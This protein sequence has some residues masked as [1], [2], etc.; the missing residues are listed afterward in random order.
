MEGAREDDPARGASVSKARERWAQG[1]RALG[2]EE[3]GQISLQ[4]KPDG[5][6]DP[7]AGRREGKR[8]IRN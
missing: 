1:N 6:I 3:G 2:E 5:I 7:G 8:E 4:R